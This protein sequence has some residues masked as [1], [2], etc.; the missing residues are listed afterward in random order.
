MRFLFLKLGLS[1]LS[2]AALFQESLGTNSLQLEPSSGALDPPP[3]EHTAPLRDCKQG[4]EDKGGLAAVKSSQ[5]LDSADAGGPRAPRDGT[6]RGGSRA[7]SRARTQGNAKEPRDSH[8]RG[9]AGHTHFGHRCRASA[10]GS[11]G[12]A[13]IKARHPVPVLPRRPPGRWQLALSPPGRGRAPSA[14]TRMETPRQARPPPKT[15][16]FLRVRSGVPE[17][18]PFWV[19]TAPAGGGRPERAGV[20]RPSPQARRCSL[21]P[22]ARSTAR[23]STAHRPPSRDRNCALAGVGPRPPERPAAERR[24]PAH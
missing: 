10:P 16:P 23:T 17:A 5:A 3:E 22:P 18:P 11:D 12:C 13:A 1:C 6:L 14:P 2:R 21:G 8:R 7:P 20:C 9:Q 24:A 15:R 4:A 19:D